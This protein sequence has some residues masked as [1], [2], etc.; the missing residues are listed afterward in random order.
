MSLRERVLIVVGVLIA[1]GL[2]VYPLAYRISSEQ[3]RAA[4]S[5]PA[6]APATQAAAPSLATPTRPPTVAPTLVDA[7]P[8]EPTEPVIN[9]SWLAN[10][11]DHRDAIGKKFTYKCQ[12]NGSFSATWGTDVYTD[13]LSV[14]TAGVHQGVITREKGGIV[15]IVIR[16][17]LNGYEGSTRNGV[18][19]KSY[20][21]WD[22]SFE[23][24]KP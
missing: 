4:A 5:P 20:G 13:D 10:A 3:A 16:K 24:V 23:V 9:P 18:T 21:P 8:V 1:V 15:T 14:C 6:Q 11:L 19:T 17:A 12:P 2:V 7:T 22:G